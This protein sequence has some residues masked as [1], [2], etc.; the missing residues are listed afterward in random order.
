MSYDGTG[1]LG[2][3]HPGPKVLMLFGGDFIVDDDGRGYADYGEDDWGREE[4]NEHVET[5]HPSPEQGKKR[6]KP[7][8][9]DGPGVV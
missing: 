5:E 6:K 8:K 2:T 4:E 3:E 7:A 1:Q 9:E